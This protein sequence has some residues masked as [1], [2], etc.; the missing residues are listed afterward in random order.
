MM[1]TLGALFLCGQV[2][3]GRPPVLALSFK[4]ASR[5]GSLISWVGRRAEHGELVDVGVPEGSPSM[6]GTPGL[7]AAVGLALRD[8]CGG[9][10][11]SP[12]PAGS[13]G[14]GSTPGDS[15]KLELWLGNDDLVDVIRITAGRDWW[16]AAEAVGA[17]RKYRE[18]RD[19]TRPPQWVD[20]LMSDTLWGTYRRV[21]PHADRR[22]A[23]VCR[24]G[25]KGCSSGGPRVPPG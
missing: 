24:R 9:R 22:G 1:S 16:T 18:A 25:R 7:S 8:V 15:S 11:G 5:F 3:V 21:H 19:R 23:Y 10:C 4:W 13:V 17:Q 20:R 12:V 6:V 14:G 2:S